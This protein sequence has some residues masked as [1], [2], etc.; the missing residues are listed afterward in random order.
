METINT[1]LSQND[2]Q[3]LEKVVITHGKIVSFDQL[4]ES[5]GTD[6]SIEGVRNRVALL[7]KKGWLLRLKRGLYMVITDISTLGFSDVSDFIIAQALNNQSYVSFES[8]LQHYGMFDQMLVTVDSVTSARARTYTVENNKSYRFFHVREDLYFGFTQVRMNG[9]LIIVAEREKALLD[10]LY[11][12]S[13]TLAASVVLEKLKEHQ[14]DIDFE[15]LKDYA[16]RYS[17]TVV[18]E[19]GFLLDRLGIETDDLYEAS[20]I[21]ENSYSKMSKEADIF[22]AK[23]RFY[24]DSKLT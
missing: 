18:R 13:N 4:V 24:Y 6:Y 14:Q 22:N 1:I 2:L 12:R 21:K 15:K 8:A 9:Q 17:L 5:Y 3:L 20:T 7:A 23:W 10:M 16:G 11:F 19:I